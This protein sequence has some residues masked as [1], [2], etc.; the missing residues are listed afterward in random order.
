MPFVN[1]RL[2][3]DGIADDPAGKKA[4][5]AKAVT[6]AIVGAIPHLT[7]TDVW[8]V[9]EEVEARDWFL[10]P[11]DVETRRKG[12]PAADAPSGEDVAYAVLARRLGVDPKVARAKLRRN[13]GMVKQHFIGDGNRWIVKA[14]SIATITAFIKDK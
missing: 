13:I 5:I 6:E 11:T 8:V 9:F 2:V 3:R 10:G 7:E 4:K 1:I 12:K 14:A